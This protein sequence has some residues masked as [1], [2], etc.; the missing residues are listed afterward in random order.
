MYN[1]SY[2][3]FLIYLVCSL[4]ILCLYHL[5]SLQS[6]LSLS[7]SPHPRLSLPEIARRLV[8]LCGSK[9]VAITDGSQG[10]VL[11]TKDNVSML[12]YTGS[13]LTI[14]FIMP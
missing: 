2:A 11:A 3:T 6:S 1:I 12:Q 14:L 4:C 5:T 10:S 9:L 13:P 7:L 8:E